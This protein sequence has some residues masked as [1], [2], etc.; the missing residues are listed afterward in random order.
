MHAFLSIPFC[1]LA[2]PFV[3]LFVALKKRPFVV[4]KKQT[5][6]VAINSQKQQPS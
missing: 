1:F 3:I 2:I 4:Y 5:V 6:N